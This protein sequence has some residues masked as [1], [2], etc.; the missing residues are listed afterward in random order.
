MPGPDT[1]AEESPVL[2]AL[3][4]ALQALLAWLIYRSLHYVWLHT[5]GWV[6]GKIANVGIPTGF[7][8]SVHPLSWLNSVNNTVMN[9]LA[10]QALANEEAMGKFFHEAARLQEWIVKELYGLGADVFNWLD[11]FHHHL[12]GRVLKA[13]IAPIEDLARAAKSVAVAAYDEALTLERK[14]IAIEHGLAGDIRGGLKRALP[15]LL[16]GIPLIGWLIKEVRGI[17]HWVARH[18][19]RLRRLEGLLGVTGMAVAMSNVFGLPNWRCLT[20]GG[21]G[22]F[23]RGFCGLPL[24]LLNDVLALIAD[25]FI[26]ETL[27]D[28]IPVLATITSDV[29][30]PLVEALTPIEAGLCD[31][32]HTVSKRL[33]AIALRLAKPIYPISAGV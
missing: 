32:N 29:A 13:L 18:N 28:V 27:C 11:H 21:V 22:R 7:F 3:Y 33:P 19:R 20:R 17:S 8:G 2:I 10:A 16:P 12:I 26:F 25:F 15:W 9:W 14:A 5:I 23:A 30:V 1:V 24:H 6:V 4:L 31:R